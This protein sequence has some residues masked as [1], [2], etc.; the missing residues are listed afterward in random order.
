[1]GSRGSRYMEAG[2]L[3]VWP[4]GMA[5]MQ[6]LRYSVLWLLL[7]GAPTR[8]DW[9]N[10]VQGAVTDAADQVKSGAGPE[11]LSVQ[12]ALSDAADKVKSDAAPKLQELLDD[13]EKFSS[14]E[15]SS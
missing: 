5:H 6:H 9:W 14:Y 7:G 13:G 2:P 8:A 3:S 10:S 12:E 15:L 11:V 1:M 4:G